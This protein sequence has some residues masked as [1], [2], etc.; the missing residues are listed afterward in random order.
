[1]NDFFIEKILEKINLCNF[2]FDCR[3]VMLKQ[4]MTIGILIFL[5][6]TKN[7]KY[8]ENI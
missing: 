4:E 7:F 8:N 1:M 5:N 3:N 6:V 2:R